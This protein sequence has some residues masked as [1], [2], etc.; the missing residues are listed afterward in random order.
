VETATLS[1]HGDLNEVVQSGDI[2]NEEHELDDSQHTL[3]VFCGRY[4]RITSEITQVHLSKNDWSQ[5]MYLAIACIDRE[6]IKYGRIQDE[7]A[8]WRKKY[9]ES[10]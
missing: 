7:L 5:I 4:I 10:K 1:R 2:Q 6:V 9:F 8:E 3:S